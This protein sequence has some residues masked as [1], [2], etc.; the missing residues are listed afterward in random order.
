M[1]SRLRMF[2]PC[3]AWINPAMRSPASSR[4]W[5][6]PPSC[7]SLRSLSSFEGGASPAPVFSAIASS[8]AAP[9]T[10]S[11]RQETDPSP[12]RRRRRASRRR[13]RGSAHPPPSGTLPL[14]LCSRLCGSQIE[15]EATS[16]LLQRRRASVRGHPRGSARRFKRRAAFI[17][18]PRVT[19]WRAELGT[20]SCSACTRSPLS[21]GRC[22]S[23]ASASRCRRS[24]PR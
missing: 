23:E 6:E 11:T 21:C 15:A 10:A 4:T 2:W 7:R 16:H 24:A 3:D 19:P 12:S 8:A 14:P 18:P 9:I 1:L 20:G 13:R 22:S 5:R 17:E